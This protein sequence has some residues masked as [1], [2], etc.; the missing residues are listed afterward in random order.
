M[1]AITRRHSQER[2][3]CHA[4]RELHLQTAFA[5][6]MTADSQYSVNRWAAI[7]VGW[8]ELLRP[9]AELRRLKRREVILKGKNHRLGP[10]AILMV[11][12]AKKRTSMAI[13]L[14]IAKADGG[15][16]D[17]YAALMRSLHFDLLPVARRASTHRCFEW[18]ITQAAE[19]TRNHARNTLAAWVRHVA[20]RGEAD[21]PNR[22]I[23]RSLR[24]EGAMELAAMGVPEF[25]LRGQGRCP[26]DAS[27]AYTRITGGQVAS[28]SA[29]MARAHPGPTLEL[30]IRRRINQSRRP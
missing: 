23:A 16:A 27:R 19:V 20:L 8:Q 7:A 25:V 28:V 6:E 2:A 22:F 5:G 15:G 14:I 10:H 9:S 26:S 29:R 11:R 21:E 30:D 3:L 18:R 4:L 17:A 13:P 12:P 24:V 1:R